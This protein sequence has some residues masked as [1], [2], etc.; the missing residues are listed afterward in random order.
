MDTRL[1]FFF[2]C[3]WPF[4]TLSLKYVRFSYSSVFVWILTMNDLKTSNLDGETN[5]KIRESLSPTKNRSLAELGSYS[6]QIICE[7]PNG[8][9]YTFEGTLFEEGMEIGKAIGPKNMLLR[10]WK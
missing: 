10:V 4:S 2:T 1:S 9:L 6:G 8:S 5:L 7:K 3:I